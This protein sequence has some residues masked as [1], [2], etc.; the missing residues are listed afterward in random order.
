MNRLCLLLF[1]LTASTGLSAQKSF[2]KNNAYIEVLGNGLALS[3]NY[4][5][6]LSDKPGPGLFLGIGLGGNKPVIPFGIK[7]LFGLKNNK[8]FIEAGAGV[9]LA[10]AGIWKDDLPATVNRY[11]YTPGFIPCLGY[12]HHT[13]YGLMWR[14]NYTPAFSRYRNIPAF[15]GVS[16]G[17]QF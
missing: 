14:I 17:W 15:F 10:E 9:T 11:A 6:Q 4:E 12:R 8:S 13:S 7:Y 16:A 5:R 3:V 2:K 1:L